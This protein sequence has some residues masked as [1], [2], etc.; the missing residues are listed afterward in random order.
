MKQV[1][2]ALVR[3]AI[4]GRGR[5]VKAELAADT[6]LS[7]TTVGQVLSAMERVGEIRS[8][9]F[10]ESSGGRKA[11]VYELDPDA[12]VV[13]GIAVGAES[14]EWR[15]A[16]AL[17]TMIA[18]GACMV[19][20]D[21]I[22]EA[23]ALIAELRGKGFG[24]R[25]ER[26]ALAVGVPGAINDG[27]VLSGP[28]RD[29]LKDVDAVALFRD[30][31]GLPV[32]V[33]ND[34]NATALGFARRAEDEGH[35]VGSI[36]YVNTNRSTLGCAG[37][38]T[39]SGIVYGGQVLR[40]AF[41]F[42]GELGHMPDLSGASFN[43]RLSGAKDSAEYAAVY[44]NALAV[45]NSVINP[46]LFVVGGTG[47][48]YDLSDAVAF[49]FACRVDPSVRPALVFEQDSGPHYLYGLC[50]LAAEELFPSY[51]LIAERS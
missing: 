19:R 29:R 37:S 32:T 14:L 3:E 20:R 6:G 41:N 40:G 46:A 5:A 39:G 43:Q 15:V 21:P 8:T 18:D 25:P 9:G 42:A 12:C 34:L 38:G 24:S 47:F 11:A 33:E 50:S 45:M 31:T 26:A 44:A 51:R 16:N 27:C 2:A 49:E 1:N 7:L 48:R 28:L 17:G 13:Y 35:P 30:R 36:V 23:I 10:K 22:E 4:A